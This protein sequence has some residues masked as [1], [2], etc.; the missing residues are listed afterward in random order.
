MGELSHA[1]S[2]ALRFGLCWQRRTAPAAE[3]LRSFAALPRLRRATRRR[4][5]PRLR[6]GRPGP[7][8]AQEPAAARGSQRDQPLPLYY[9]SL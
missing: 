6:A 5:L 7:G 3:R 9:K 2:H 1:P 8:G 4:G